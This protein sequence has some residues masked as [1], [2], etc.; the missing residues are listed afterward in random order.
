MKGH[1]MKNKKKDKPTA[2]S[3]RLQPSQKIRHTCITC[4]LTLL[5]MVLEKLSNN[6]IGE[7]WFIC[8]YWISNENK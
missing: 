5:I 8:K 6:S 7:D 3:L 4:S 2:R 1:S